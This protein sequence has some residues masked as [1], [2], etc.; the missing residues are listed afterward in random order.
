MKKKFI[1]I[2]IV[3]LFTSLMLFALSP[4]IV[5]KYNNY[6]KDKLE[7]HATLYCGKQVS[8]FNA[9]YKMFEGVAFFDCGMFDGN[10]YMINDETFEIVILDKKELK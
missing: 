3:L 4:V 6:K 7:Y 10:T 2:Q 8:I 1:L 9:Q 5:N